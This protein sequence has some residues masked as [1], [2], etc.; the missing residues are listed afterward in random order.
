MPGMTAVVGVTMTGMT[1]RRS[2][3]VM[4]VLPVIV[5]A[6]IVA[7]VVGV[8]RSLVVHPVRIPPWG[9]PRYRFPFIQRYMY[10]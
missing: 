2:H 1:R 8:G 4:T 10:F 5:V 6:V 9:M 3:L 7:T